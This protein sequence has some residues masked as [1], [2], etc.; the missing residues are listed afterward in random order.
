V[1]GITNLD[2]F[3]TPSLKSNDF[4]RSSGA[5][6]ETWLQPRRRL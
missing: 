3:Q 2:H 5:V 4:W 6:I 1:Q